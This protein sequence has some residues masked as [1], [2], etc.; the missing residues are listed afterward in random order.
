[1]KALIIYDSVHGNTEKVANAIGQ[2]IH[3]EVKVLKVSEAD[4]VD[5][6]TYN[7][8]IIGSP[9][10]GG[11]PTQALQNYFNNLA[12]NSLE[13]V[14]VTAFDTRFKAFWVKIF[15]FA[16]GRIADVLKSKGGHLVEAH[17]GFF[18]E[19]REG[20]L[21]DGELDRATN[22]GKTILENLGNRCARRI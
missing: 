19:G 8:V 5:L 13:G 9:T 2:G 22:W 21:L 3:S 10:H 17:M 1:M 7:L 14:E 6:K 12:D 20:P 4:S 11:R 18:V 16:A 15:G